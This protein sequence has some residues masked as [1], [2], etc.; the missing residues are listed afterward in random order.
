MLSPMVS[1]ALS[2]QTNP[3]V[4][5]LLLG[6]GISRSS[7][8]PT[9]WE[10]VQDLIRKV[11][12]LEDADCQ[13]DPIAWYRDRFGGDEPDYST[14]LD[15]LG[16]TAAERNSLLRGYFE[17]TADEREQG[18][19]LPTPAHRAIGRLVRDGYVKLILTTNFDRLTELAIEAEGITP[20]VI[21][22]P[23]QLKGSFPLQHTTCTVLKL[24]GDYLDTRT[25]N[26]ADELATYDAV[27][28]PLLDRIFVEYGLIICG[29][30][31]EWD[32]ALRNAIERCPVFQFTCFWANPTDLGKKGSALADRRRAVRV[33]I[34]SADVFFTELAEKVEAVAGMTAHP[35]SPTL[36]TATAK[37]YLAEERYTI[38]LFDLIASEVNYVRERRQE[39]RFAI[40][41]L[42]P[43]KDT[44][45]A[46][47]RAYEELTSR[48][49]ALFAV[50][51][52]WSN[53][54]QAGQWAVALTRLAQVDAIQGHSYDAW[55]ALRKY[56]ALLCMYAAGLSAMASDNFAVITAIFSAYIED[57][58]TGRERDL[59]VD[60]LAPPRVMQKHVGNLLGGREKQYTP[61]NEHL[62]E[63]L[64]EPLR[65]FLP[66]DEE[67]ERAFDRFELLLSLQAGSGPATWFPMGR[68]GWKATHRWYNS[69]LERE[70]GMPNGKIDPEWAPIKAGM[71]GGSTERLPEL[72]KGLSE[73]IGKCGF[74]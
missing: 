44:L 68:F 39:E 20:S 56:P 12:A 16:G 47:L 70:I 3:G 51:S 54:G 25:K 9:A 26:T 23:D 10:V 63:I 48:L 41:G 28:A 74:F 49:V 35:L 18:I 2:V 43:G 13:P 61:T 72:I 27:L 50:G 53:K 57:K 11:A 52:F 24:H 65:E 67:Y 36:M 6:S 42:P 38:P 71:F 1:L 32:V 46:R 37:K 7:G 60:R 59:L 22:T 62:F 19:K 34:E 73:A 69:T 8:I 5:A 31:G 33:P 64:R 55:V 40:G 58:G 4:Y 45:A 21:S 66:S 15:K 30:S 29:W 17:P 14:L